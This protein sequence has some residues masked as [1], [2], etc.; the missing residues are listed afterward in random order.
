MNYWE[1]CIKES[2]DEAGIV[3]TDA[4]VAIV[5]SWVEGGHENYGMAHGNDVIGNP[6][7]SEIE[8]LKKQLEI[9]KEKRP[10]PDCKGSGEEV[11]YGGTRMSRTTCFRCNGEGK[12][13]RYSGRVTP[14]LT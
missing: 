11:T 14:Y 9:E 10:C 5:V 8:T 12:C 2:F 3:A 1:E 6:R 13:L 4:Q 7:D